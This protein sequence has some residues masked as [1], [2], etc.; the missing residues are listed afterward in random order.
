[1]LYIPREHRVTIEVDNDVS[2]NL[3]MALTNDQLQLVEIKKKENA[4]NKLYPIRN[5]TRN[6]RLQYLII[7]L[8]RVRELFGLYYF[9]RVTEMSLRNFNMYNT[10]SGGLPPNLDELTVYAD[11][12]TRNIN[13]RATLPMSLRNLFASGFIDS[14]LITVMFDVDSLR[15]RPEF[16]KFRTELQIWK[17]PIFS[18]LNSENITDAVWKIWDTK[19]SEATI[20]SLH[21]AVSA[22]RPE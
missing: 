20:Q 11:A 6:S 21:D 16:N 19:Y 12:D 22:M 4:D 5:C 17:V 14:D 9:E 8:S 10:I 18:N 2:H 1:M 7:D 3:N 13:F 15:E